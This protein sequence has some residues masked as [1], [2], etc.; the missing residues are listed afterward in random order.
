MVGNGKGAGFIC[1]GVGL[2][3]RSGLLIQYLNADI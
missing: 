2:Y 3:V 1:T